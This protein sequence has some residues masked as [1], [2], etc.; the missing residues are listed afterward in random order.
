MNEIQNVFIDSNVLVHWYLIKQ[1]IKYKKEKHKKVILEKY[2]NLKQ[3]YDFIECI[4]NNRIKGFNFFISDLVLS[5]MVT[6]IND[7]YISKKMD[8]HG[9]ATIY[10]PKYRKD[11]LLDKNESREFEDDAINAIDFL[12][13]KLD[14]LVDVLLDRQYYPHFIS[15]YGLRT[16]DSILLTTAIKSNKGKINF[17]VSMDRDFLELENSLENDLKIK[18]VKPQRMSEIIKKKTLENERI[19]EVE[20]SLP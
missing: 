6:I 4:T 10:W 12:S 14:N 16:H 11:F 18:I 9:I 7:F 1:R 3:S 20:L 5:E 15:K 8:F 17:L 2:R 13:D 19:R